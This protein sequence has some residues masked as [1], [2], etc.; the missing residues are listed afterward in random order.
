MK[1]SLNWLK[2]YI[3]PKLPTEALAQRL[4]MAGWDVEAI[5]TVGK[6]I[7]FEIEVTPN[8]P[9]CL[10]VWGLAREVA[11][12]TGKRA[13]FP[14]CRIYKSINNIPITIEDRKDCSRYIGTLIKEGTV[15]NSSLEITGRLNAIGLRPVNN[16]VD[17]T[18]FV[19][20]ETGQPLHVF[21]Y[22]KLIGGKIIVRRA[23]SGEKIITIDGLE[24]ALDP[25]ILV[26]A[27]AQRPVAIA[28]IMGGKDTEVTLSTKNILL[29]SAHFD[30]TLIR[31][32]SRQLGLRSESS[33]RFE[34]NVDWA[35]VLT[36]A[37]R[38]T[39]LL[40]EFTKGQ[41]AGRT[42]KAYLPKGA[43][44][45]FKIT[46]EQVE[47]LLGTKVP[48]SKIKSILIALEFKVSGNGSSLTV[49][50][51]S[52]RQDVKA[53]V[54]LIEEIA[55]MIG[56]DRLPMSLPQ[57]KAQNLA[58]DPRPAQIKRTVREVLRAVDVDEVVT[59]SMT[60]TKDMAKCQ[61]QEYTSASVKVFN[62]LNVDQELMRLTLVPS[63]LQVAL[64]NINRGQKD[65]RI[66]EVAK[67]YEQGGERDTLGI[68]LMGRR[69][70]DW[71]LN[72]KDSVEFADLKG[73]LD[74]IVKALHIKVSLEA[75]SNPVFDSSAGAEIVLKGKV[76][77]GLGKIDRKVLKH[78]DIKSQDIYFAGM[79]LEEIYQ[80]P[81]PKIKYQPI[82][83]FPA[84]VRD[85]SI[86]VKKGVSYK[87]IE[88]VCYLK[89]GD[90]LQEVKFIEQYRGDK[91]S[92]GQKALIFSL[93]Y[94][95]HQ[96][97]LREEEVNS[98][99]ERIIQTLVQQLAAIRR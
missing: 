55:R 40:L 59:L 74:A 17:V 9:D 92:A 50:S 69:Y 36:G 32:A 41:W 30:M 89:G 21:D 35:G 20:M 85:V 11:A 64:T 38:A 98:A 22:D 78:W 58:V 7:V 82:S 53:S 56:Y 24:R 43:S 79:D 6:D 95:S 77:G 76:I 54:D 83:E 15:A 27:D 18:N 45:P 39:D 5:E 93:I 62:P 91:V 96:R 61:L 90:I 29:E 31:R 16:V 28:G 72:K 99:H 26:I 68:L 44:L 84:I 73:I 71:R 2:S 88:D 52:F 49:T 33:Y 34:R 1:L 81:Q 51:P 19:L 10:N 14:R 67:R 75:S 86:A 8:R 3:D 57:V 87:S 12:I 70:T 48:A 47:N 66:F 80:L 46:A 65:L 23:K 97:T 94:Q 13:S 4:V 63:L 37:N 60:N 42:D 25:S